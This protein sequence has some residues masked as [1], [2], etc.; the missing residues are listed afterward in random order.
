[1]MLTERNVCLR[2]LRIQI[3]NLFLKVFK[4]FS[5]VCMLD[6]KPRYHQFG[7]TLPAAG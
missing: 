4:S 1:M 6:K 5:S 7:R 3:E 2:I